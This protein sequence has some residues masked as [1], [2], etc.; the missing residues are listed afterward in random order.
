MADESTPLSDEERAEL[1]A[2][3]AEQA[4]R[5]EA[6]RAA[7]ERAELERLRAQQAQAAHDAAEDA[8]I[9]QIKE[10][11]HDFVEPDEE[12][13]M[14]LMQKVVLIVLAVVVAIFVAEAI[15]R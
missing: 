9:A 7:R 14:P 6:E 10:K 8:R 4:K 13:R 1:E 2:L 11:T 5:D 15:L 12:Y 3:R